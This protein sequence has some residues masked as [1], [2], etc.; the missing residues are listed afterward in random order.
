M[1][2]RVERKKAGSGQLAAGRGQ[3]KEVLLWER[4]SS[5]ELNN[6]HNLNSFDDL[7]NQRVNEFSNRL[8]TTGYKIWDRR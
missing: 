8:P 7:T 1:G 2:H 3:K 5:R 4:L 6:F